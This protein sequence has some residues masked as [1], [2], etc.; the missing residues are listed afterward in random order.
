VSLNLFEEGIS[1]KWEDPKN[2]YGKT[3]TLQY[4]IKGDDL[5]TFLSS[6]QNYW[7]KLMLYVVGES[8]PGAKYVILFLK[9]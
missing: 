6:I 8:I 7:L 3:L 9:K 5:D 2:N 4:E 1:P